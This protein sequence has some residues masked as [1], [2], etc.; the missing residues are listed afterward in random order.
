VVPTTYIS[1]KVRFLLQADL[2][3]LLLYLRGAEKVVQK[4]SKKVFDKVV[5]LSYLHH[6]LNALVQ[7]SYYVLLIELK[8]WDF[9]KN[10]LFRYVNNFFSFFFI[11]SL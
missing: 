3:F 6:M 9:D 1:L 2:A 4:R 7:G 11:S 5:N 10:F 8:Y